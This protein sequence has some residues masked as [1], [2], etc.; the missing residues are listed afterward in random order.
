V[1][2]SSR[3]VYVDALYHGASGLFSGPV[4]QPQDVTHADLILVTHA[5][6]DHFDPRGVAA[7]VRGTQ[8]TVV[9]PRTAI[10]ALGKEGVAAERIREAEPPSCPRG[11]PAPWVSLDISGIRVTAYRTCHSP[12]HNSYLV[13]VP[14]FRFFH[15]GDNED[16]RVLDV[17]ALGSLDALLIGP[18]QGSGWVEF[19]ETLRPRAT[20]VMHL[21]DQELAEHEA[22]R[23]FPEIC[24]HVPE[25]LIVLRPGQSWTDPGR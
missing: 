6:G 24:D 4:L 25:G 13:E 3:R 22:G 9:G 5:H 10:R 19:I 11:G 12:D 20:F 16:T 15:D 18:W 21:D 8:A 1:Q 14:G 7:V 2:A 17:Q 23:F